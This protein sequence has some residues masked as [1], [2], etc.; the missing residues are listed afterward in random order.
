MGPLHL[1]QLQ[2]H[3]LCQT[4]DNALEARSLSL[5]GHIM[6]YRQIRHKAVGAPIRSG[7]L[8]QF[9]SYVKLSTSDRY[10]K[11]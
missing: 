11:N 4:P 7:G 3:C 1:R 8:R 2:D 5:S 6:I 10:C 9:E